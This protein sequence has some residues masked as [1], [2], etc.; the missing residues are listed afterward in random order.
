MNETWVKAKLITD[1]IEKIGQLRPQL[2]TFN[3]HSFDFRP[4]QAAQCVMWIM[5]MHTSASAR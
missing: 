3:G 1:F 2:V 4:L 5:L